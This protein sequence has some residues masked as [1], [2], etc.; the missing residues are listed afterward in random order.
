MPGAYTICL[1]TSIPT[2]QHARRKVSIECREAIKK[3][4]H[5]MVDQAIITP[6]T[7]STV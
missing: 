5:E 1:D 6:V 3:L 2:V 7:K 4:L